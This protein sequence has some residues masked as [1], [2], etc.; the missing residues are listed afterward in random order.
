[1]TDEDLL[2]KVHGLGDLGLAALLCLISREHC[3]ISTEPA[4][5]DDLAAELQLVASQTFD[6]TPIIVGCTP[7]TTLDEFAAAI[8]LPQQP[9]ANASTPHSTSPLRTRGADS[10]FHAHPHHQ[11]NNHGHGGSGGGNG[12]GNGGGSGGNSSTHLQ[13]HHATPLRALSPISP[14]L[15]TP[16]YATPTPQIAPVVL[17]KNLDRAP[18][19]VQIQALE[20]L[21]TRRI[22]TRTSVQTCPKQFLFVAVLGAGARLT[23]H[24][25]DFFYIAH[26]HDPEDG[27]A[28]LEE[29]EEE[30]EGEDE[31][32]YGGGGLGDEHGDRDDAASLESGSS[33]IHRRSRKQ[34]DGRRTSTAGMGTP[35][36]ADW[37]RNHGHTQNHS[38]NHNS[39]HKHPTTPGPPA[40]DEPP[41]PTLTE[42]DITTLSHLSQTIAVDIEVQRYQ[43]NII[44]HLRLHRAV[45]PGGTSVPPLATHHFSALLRSLAAL[46]GLDYATPA[47]VGLA[48]RKIYLHRIRVVEPQRERSMQWGSDLAAVE[49]LLRDV[50]PEDVIEDVLGLVAPPL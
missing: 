31:G 34:S 49:A 2:Q 8:Q 42:P 24:L 13:H 32:G 29:E 23:P 19:A 12:N 48:A 20:L 35:T 38:H 26:W 10:Y 25:N 39:T 50:G 27:F 30:R 37:T 47:L 45:A 4:S 18:K 15:N 43:M 44:S 11:N 21:R 5:L 7:Q 28:H 9:N 36:A 16:S 6:L 46:H 40:A 1:M 41:I 17:A 33:V 14:S 22:F 3:I